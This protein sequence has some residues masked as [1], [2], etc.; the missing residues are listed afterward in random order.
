MVVIT[1]AILYGIFLDAS[2]FLMAAGGDGSYVFFGLYSAPISL[3]GCV[4][5][6]CGL[7]SFIGIPVLW[8]MAVILGTICE[9]VKRRVYL[10]AFLLIHYVGAALVLQT[11]TYGNWKKLHEQWDFVDGKLVILF[12]LTVYLLGQIWLWLQFLRSFSSKDKQP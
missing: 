3:L 5:P 9:K 1:M 7:I 2:A 6:L 4:I 10:G 11:E 12:S 8:I